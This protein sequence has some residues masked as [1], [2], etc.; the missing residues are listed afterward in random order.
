MPRKGRNPLPPEMMRG[1]GFL[2]NAFYH[3]EGRGRFR[4]CPCHG[5]DHPDRELQA[6]PHS[7]LL[8]DEQHREQRLVFGD[9][10]QEMIFLL[11]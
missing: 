4:S 2:L 7:L 10:R 9:A 11:A 8:L 3:G 6:L 5:C 1:R